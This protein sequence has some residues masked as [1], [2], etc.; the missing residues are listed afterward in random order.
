MIRLL[1]VT[2]QIGWLEYPL[3]AAFGTLRRFPNLLPICKHVATL[4]ATCRLYD[5]LFPSIPDRERDVFDV[6]ID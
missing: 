2:N 1:H 5:Q 4:P 3:R 6:L